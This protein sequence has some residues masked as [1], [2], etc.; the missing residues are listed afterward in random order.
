MKFLALTALCCGCATIF[1]GTHDMMSFDSNAPGTRL[2][3]DGQ[4]MG[5]LPL[6]ID[7][8]R[9]FMGGKHFHARFEAEGFVTQEFDLNREF[10]T[11]AI[12]D[13]TDPITCGGIDALTGSMLRF[14]PTAYRIQMLLQGESSEAAEF[15]RKLESVRFGLY[16]YGRLREDLARGGGEYLRSFAFVLSGGDAAASRLIVAR[17]LRDAPALVTAPTPPI[18]VARFD[19]MLDEDPA[20]RAYRTH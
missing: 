11:V 14:S 7:M 3:I 1:T 10:N 8:S 13:I 19:A 16:N 12:L 6:Q 9:N 18:F 15:Q 2:T 5:V 20:L 4:Y 17:S